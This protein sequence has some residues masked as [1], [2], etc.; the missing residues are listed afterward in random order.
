MYVKIQTQMNII[1]ASSPPASGRHPAFKNNF[2]TDENRAKITKFT[3]LRK[4]EAYDVN[5]NLP[6]EPESQR[7]QAGC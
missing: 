4:M 6:G 3:S 5:E 2:F 7:Y 1:D